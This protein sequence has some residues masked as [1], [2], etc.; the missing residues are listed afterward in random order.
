[1]TPGLS[2]GYIDYFEPA[3]A[4]EKGRPAFTT[5]YTALEWRRSCKDR[6]LCSMLCALL[7]LIFNCTSDTSVGIWLIYYGIAS[8]NRDAYL[9]WFEGRHIDEKLARP[10]YDW[11]C[12]YEVTYGG[13]PDH[14]DHVYIAMFGG[15]TT[16]PFFDP[17]PAQIK[18][19][20]DE[21][22]RSM[23]GHRIKATSAILTD[24]W[25]ERPDSV[26]HRHDESA[27]VNSPAIRLGVFTP[28]VNDQE[29]V[30]WCAQRHFPA[31]AESTGLTIARKWLASFGANRHMV[32][33]EYKDEA[34][35]ATTAG[36]WQEQPATS[37]MSEPSTALLRVFRQ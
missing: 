20:Q 33:E 34:S 10:G 17:S 37:L 6:R 19:N 12:H 23:I 28:A 36:A 35:A 24:E 1:M 25:C 32:L 26:T 29:T 22:T 14:A 7:L 2:R 21:L 30:A 4:A 3:R 18:P 15:K 8:A 9:H 13:L 5:C 16:R 27:G 11:A 31:L